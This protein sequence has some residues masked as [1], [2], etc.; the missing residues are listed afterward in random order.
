MGE[1]AEG[2]RESGCGAGKE[3][4]RAKEEREREAEDKQAHARRETAIEAE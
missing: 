4:L 3:H 1:G 2:G